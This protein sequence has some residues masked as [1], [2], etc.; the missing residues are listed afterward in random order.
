LPIRVLRACDR[1]FAIQ[2]ADE[3]TADLLDV[4]FCRLVV[5]SATSIPP[6]KTS[7]WIDRDRATREFRIC[8]ADGRAARFEDADGLLFHLDKCL[9][10]A[11]QLQR[12]EFCFLHAAAVAI[13]DRVAVLAAPPGTGKSTLTMALLGRGLAYLSDELAPIDVTRLRVF[14]YAHAVGLKSRPPEPFRLPQGTVGIGKRFHVTPSL[15]PAATVDEALPLAA[16][17]FLRRAAGSAP[18]SRRISAAAGAAHALANMLNP[19]AH[20]RDGLNVAADLAQRAPCFEV[21][22][23]DL[24]AACAAVEDILTVRPHEQNLT[25]VIDES[26]SA[27]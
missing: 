22:I 8:D 15:F 11:L 16:L 21:N 26:S 27:Q 19:L 12:P 17:V 25:Q 6:F 5:R 10:I 4:A 18:I 3:E 9:I 20:Q 13:G 23:V 24:K 7:Y 2:C 14:P 1:A